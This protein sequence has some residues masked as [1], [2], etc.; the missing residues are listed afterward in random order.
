MHLAL[1]AICGEQVA[2]QNADESCIKLRKAEQV[3]HPEGPLH[4][5]QDLFTTEKHSQKKRHHH[6]HHH[7]HPMNSA[8]CCFL[9][10][11]SHCRG[12]NPS[13]PWHLPS[14]R[15]TRDAPPGTKRVERGGLGT[16]CDDMRRHGTTGVPHLE[17]ISSC[18]LHGT[19]DI[20]PVELR[21]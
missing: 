14:S 17:A 6:Q 1:F 20:S 7:Q 16:T 8:L 19:Q 15:R 13:Q 10:T 4:D 18:R 9:G 12:R 2:V 11:C 3:F 5:L 21:E